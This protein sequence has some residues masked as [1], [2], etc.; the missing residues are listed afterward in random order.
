MQGETLEVVTVNFEEKD[1]GVREKRFTPDELQSIFG[2]QQV[3]EILQIL[4]TFM[5]SETEPNLIATYSLDLLFHP[6]ASVRAA[7]VTLLGFLADR[8]KGERYLEAIKTLPFL[9]ADPNPS[10]VKNTEEAIKKLEQHW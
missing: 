10:V 4:K 8:L 5:H 7:A 3:N 1:L 6:S 2:S 9:L